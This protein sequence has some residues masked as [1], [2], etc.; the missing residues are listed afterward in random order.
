[1]PTTDIMLSRQQ[2]G[3]TVGFRCCA[4]LL[5]VALLKDEQV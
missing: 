2:F 5:S 4:Q 1:M 3:N